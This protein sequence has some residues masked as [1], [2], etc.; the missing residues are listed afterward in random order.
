MSVLNGSSIFMLLPEDIIAL[1][2]RSK[3]ETFDYVFFWKETPKEVGKLDHSCLSQ[4]WP[5]TFK[6]GEQEFPTAEHFMMHSKAVL[7]K[8]EEI[9]EKILQTESCKEV[10]AL[11][12]QVRNF[13]SELWREHRFAIVLR[14]NLAKFSQNEELKDF[15][16]STGDTVIVEA[17]PFDTIWGIGL[18]EKKAR[19][20]PTRDWRGLNLLGFALMR[21]RSLLESG[22]EYVSEFLNMGPDN[23]PLS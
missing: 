13:D 22:L 20:I 2:K 18:G 14:G 12:R 6:I 10:K 11:G 17:S 4:W 21:T 1:K 23:Q 5:A 15:I 19:K 9:A 7:F 8:D 3:E 16:F